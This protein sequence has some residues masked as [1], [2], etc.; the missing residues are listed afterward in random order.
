[1]KKLGTA[2]LCNLRIAVFE[3][4]SAERDAL[5]ESFGYFD[6]QR[7]EIWTREGLSPALWANTL[8]HEMLHAIMAESGAGE[9]LRVAIE[10]G[11]DAGDTEETL[12]RI[13]VPH[14]QAAMREGERLGRRA[15]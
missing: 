6:P 11:A 2:T 8:F 5:G 1:M 3:G 9:F 13:L 14:L 7:L 12:I 4:T 15:R 10:S